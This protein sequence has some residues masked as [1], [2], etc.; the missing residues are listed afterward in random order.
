[1]STGQET[2]WSPDLHVHAHILGTNARSQATR[3]RLARILAKP[4]RSC[5]MHKLSGDVVFIGSDTNE[6]HVHT[7]LAW[8]SSH[9]IE[10]VGPQGSTIS[11]PVT[12]DVDACIQALPT[13]VKYRCSGMTTPY[14]FWG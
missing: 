2:A 12:K 3:D 13:D 9:K 8:R 10:L 1:M 4:Y 14:D 11:I 6:E 7:C 5:V